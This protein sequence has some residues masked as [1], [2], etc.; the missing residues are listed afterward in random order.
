MQTPEE[1]A[2]ERI[3]AARR[4]EATDLYL[5][6]SYLAQQVQMFQRVDAWLPVG[7]STPPPTRA[8]NPIKRTEGAATRGGSGKKKGAA[9]CSAAPQS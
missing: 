4:S 3:E 9:L 1:V 8:I 5:G 7:D 2:E 6:G